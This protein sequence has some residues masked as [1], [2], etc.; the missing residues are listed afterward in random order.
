MASIADI[1]TPDFNPI[2]QGV[3]LGQQ[4]A[5]TRQTN[6][7]TRLM[8]VNTAITA[9]NSLNQ[10][11]AT[12][13]SNSRFNNPA[14]NLYKMMMIAPKATRDAYIAQ[15]PQQ[16]NQAV[17]AAQQ[18]SQNASAAQAPDYLT[19]QL[20]SAGFAP[21][22]APSLG[23][24][25]APADGQDVSMGQAPQT[26]LT[27]P[28]V[29]D[30]TNQQNLD[31]IKRTAEMSSNND[32]TT[33]K[34]RSRQ[35]YGSA[36]EQFMNSPDVQQSLSVIGR[37]DGPQGHLELINDKLF[38]PM[39]YQQFKSASTQLSALIS[40]GLKVLEGQPTTDQAV[41]SAKAFLTRGQ[42]LLG[43][44]PAAAQYYVKQGLALL[45]SEYESV[46]KSAEPVFSVNRIQGGNS[47]TPPKSNSAMA[48]I[49]APD[50]QIYNV[51]QEDIAEALKA[52]GKQIG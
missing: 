24:P 41:A 11:A 34:T 44:D 28:Y 16:W 23:Q 12:A 46:N 26:H 49:K 50:G 31:A 43:S 36:L 37:Y 1:Q 40:G 52:G 21:A 17:Q 29:G 4:I 35:E 22:N 6:E 39:R 47:S 7:Q 10:R 51:P 3:A 45:K 15:N 32:L 5:N 20:N 9:Q 48:K 25:A 13:L 18:V 27:S 2:A 14:Y 19:N 42:Q 8:P 38:N 30:A 33:G